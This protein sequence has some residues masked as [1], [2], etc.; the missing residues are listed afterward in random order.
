M[1]QS[2][3]QSIVG[4]TVDSLKNLSLHSTDTTTD[5]RQR[6]I[7]IKASE[8]QL[9]TARSVIVPALDQATGTPVVLKHVKNPQA[10]AQEKA[11]LRRLANAQIPH[12]LTLLDSYTGEDGSTVLVFPTL[13]P[14]NVRNLDLVAV[15]R[16][17]GQLATVLD[18]IHKLK[19]IHTQIAVQ[20]LLQDDSGALVLISW[21]H[22]NLLTPVADDAQHPTLTTTEAERAAAPLPPDFAA[23]DV[24]A[25]GCILGQWLEPY[26]PDCSLNYLG[27]RLV[28][29]STTTYIS[30][31]L[32]DSM[33][34]QLM[35][36][37]A[38]WHPAVFHAA[39]LLSRMLDADDIV[40]IT[41]EEILRHPFITAEVEDFLGTDYQTYQNEL[42]MIGLRGA[43]RSSAMEREPRIFTRG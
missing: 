21:S 17:A 29:K 23:P 16:L 33:D 34:A 5:S 32:L 12:T 3:V 8:S 38:P 20:N 28:R 14:L 43:A 36:R 1:A 10:A 35:G 30:R 11:V 25:A 18:G 4:L 27:S 2:A 19:M 6:Y 42:A 26:I 40:R 13:L 39:D 41:A 9:Q 15:S 37:A 31:K 24:Y 7:P 22:A